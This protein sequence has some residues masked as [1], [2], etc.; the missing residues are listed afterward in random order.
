ME[1]KKNFDF[2]VVDNI[3]DRCARKRFCRER[4]RPA[5]DHK[6]TTWCNMFVERKPE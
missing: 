6:K 3:C 4:T 2:A 1:E 5:K